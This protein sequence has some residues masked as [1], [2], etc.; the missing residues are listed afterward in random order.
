MDRELSEIKKEIIE[1]LKQKGAFNDKKGNVD[2]EAVKRHT[3][4]ERNSALINLAKKHRIIGK[5]K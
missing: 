3:Q 1:E 5:D 2:E 4:R